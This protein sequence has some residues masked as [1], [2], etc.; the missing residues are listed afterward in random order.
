[1][2]GLGE[3]VKEGFGAVV[4]SSMADKCDAQIAACG[5]AHALVLGFAWDKDED[6]DQDEDE[7][8][9]NGEDGEKKEAG[10]GSGVIGSEYSRASGCR[11]RVAAR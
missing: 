7:D 1:M 4:I 5:G 9:D 6:E 10:D 3:K 11:C 8:G 2:L